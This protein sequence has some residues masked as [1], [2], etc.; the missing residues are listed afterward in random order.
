MDDLHLEE[1][2]RCLKPDDRTTMLV[3]V[4]AF[5]S[6]QHNHIMRSAIYG[7]IFALSGQLREDVSVY[8]IIGA[9]IVSTNPRRMEIDQHTAVCPRP[10]IKLTDIPKV[11]ELCAGIGC[12][13]VGLKH[14][15]MEIVLL[16]DISQ[17]IS[18]LSQQLHKCQTV[19]GDV[20]ND[21]T[22]AEVCKAV[23]YSCTVAGGVPC[24]PYSRLGDKRAKLDP[25]ARTLPSVLRASLLMRH[26]VVI[27]ECVDEAYKCDW[28]QTVLKTFQ[29]LTGYFLHQQIEQLSHVWPAKRNR[30]WCV[31]T[32]PMLGKIEWSNLPKVNPTPLVSHVID[33][34]MECT[35]EELK[36]LELDTYELRH[37]D[38]QGFH[39]NLVPLHGKMATSL[40]S[41]GN[42]F[43]AC[44]CKC[45]SHPFTSDRISTGL[46]SLLV[47]IKGEIKLAGESFPRH[48][49]IHPC[50]LALLNGMFPDMQW[51]D[52]VK[53]ALAG[54]GQLASPLQ[55]CWIGSHVCQHLMTKGLLNS[56]AS[57]PHEKLASL[58]QELLRSRDKC[59]GAPK[60]A[61]AKVFQAM[62]S[63]GKFEM[64]HWKTVLGPSSENHQKSAASG[65]TPPEAPQMQPICTHPQN[66][67]H[68]HKQEGISCKA[69]QSILTLSQGFGDGLTDSEFAE[70]LKVGPSTTCQQWMSNSGGVMGFAVKPP[71][72]QEKEE[73]PLASPPV[74]FDTT[75]PVGDVNTGIVNDV[76]VKE[77]S[78]EQ[79][80]TI[81]EDRQEEEPNKEKL[82][83]VL[84]LATDH[85]AFDVL[86]TPGSTAGQLTQAEVAMGNG[87]HPMF[88]CDWVGSAL[89][90][91]APLENEQVVVI[92]EA[93]TICDHGC[94]AK[95]PNVVA[96]LIS[97]PCDRMQ[98]LFQ[99]LGWVALDEMTFY[100]QHI[101]PADHRVVTPLCHA[102]GKPLQ[103]EHKEWISEMILN[104]HH[105]K[106]V[107]S[108]IL[109][110]QHWIPIITHTEDNEI[111]IGTTY[112][113]GIDQDLTD[114]IEGLTQSAQMFSSTIQVQR[115]SMTSLFQG[116]CGFQTVS[117]LKNKIHSKQ[118]VGMKPKEAERFRRLFAAQL[119]QDNN[120]TQIV[121]GLRMGGMIRD[122][123]AH[124]KLITLLIDHGVF[125]ERAKARAD[126]IQNK[127]SSNVLGGILQSPKPWHD[128]KAAA[129][130]LTP[131]LKLVMADE[132]EKQIAARS[133]D[134]TSIG[135]KKQRNMR[136]AK[137]KTQIQVHASALSVPAGVFKQEDGK[138]VS[139][140]RQDE[141]GPNAMG[142]VLLDDCEA[143][144]MLKL[145][146]P[147]S[148]HGLA[149]I[150]IPAPGQ[151]VDL[152]S[153]I[154]FPVMC[155]KTAEPMIIN[156]SI[157]QLGQQEIRRHEPSHKIAVDVKEASVI[158]CLTYKDQAGV[159]WNS[160]QQQPVKQ[161]FASTP[162]LTKQT[163]E[164]SVVMD[165][166]DRQW[167]TKR[168]ER[169]KY[170]QADIFAFSM[171]IAT[172]EVD[173]LLSQSGSKGIY[174]EPRST[175]G[176]MP[177]PE[178]HVTWLNQTNHSEAKIAQ[179]TS[180]Q[181]TT[182]V[183]HG[184]RYGLRSDSM[185]AQEIHAK[186]RPDTPMLLGNTK[187]LYVLGPLP[188][189]TT[190]EGVGKLLKAWQWDARALQ[191]R[192]RALDGTGINWSIQ[193]TEDP[194]HWIFTLQHGDV[195][196]TKA[197]AERTPV[198]PETCGIIASRKTIDQFKHTKVD[199]SW[200]K[201][202]PWGKYTPT[203]A[204]HVEAP[205]AQSSAGISNA[206][207]AAVEANVEKR[208]MA[209]LATRAEDVSM[210][211]NMHEVVQKVTQLEH[212][213]SQVVHHQQQVDSRLNG[214]Q[215]QMDQQASQFAT[216]VATQMTA[217]M[218]RIESLLAKRSRME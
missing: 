193:A 188:F 121:T 129:N 178:Y 152:Q 111:V 151:Q 60:E 124:A 7:Q 12:L 71:P 171:R 139:Q 134:P 6:E 30:W 27:L 131:V 98:A 18:E 146:R 198:P 13:G 73:V 118:D 26:A 175:C 42:Q 197:Q 39:N 2:I 107:V 83:I 93:N 15:G 203:T 19:V 104:T 120:A 162:E 218:E 117:W 9:K 101:C 47:K 53:L 128:L 50:E 179:Q 35:M 164:E 89:S 165:V 36:K 75:S 195:L 192:G 105:F 172:T 140:L 158:R 182:L 91:Y 90:L 109:Q 64:P 168:F 116:D 177:S 127:I 191:P 169:T 31:L 110:D 156:G 77:C 65:T 200:P 76:V 196:I 3:E 214:M 213:L 115:T 212:Q 201:G 52:N 149:I 11:I 22:M 87:D 32:H 92:H 159:L 99:Q 10:P 55:S 148:Q 33:H 88:P 216:A 153:S 180:P 69:G 40:H 155:I 173:G 183:R 25:R 123:D 81:E 70:A 136:A 189:S 17:P 106:Y 215:T 163:K 186:H 49:Y 80:A 167:F 141:V 37:F 176:R 29:T 205:R 41:I 21:L 211:A 170:D 67:H 154:R 137:E 160:L 202:D 94:P 51:G 184:D 4:L 133:K 23:P 63:Q 157:H 166:W 28:V 102:K 174:F 78:S 100:L 210:E 204:Q 66:T 181:A 147:V 43:T 82:Q 114:I 85:V 209:S 46:H 217:Q 138:L 59:F 1:D 143:E 142:V 126:V 24:Q 58:M 68:A 150:V 144:A 103:E 119:Y 84:Q 190:R 125:T 62:V 194:S 16:N 187:Q 145:T 113:L 74:P 72:N 208:V 5:D 206:Q 135:N 20:C 132:L 14:A 61:N 108:A 57:T 122:P 8:L 207:I 34:F 48:R 112:D 44:P 96:P 130:Q 161:I 86:V 56:H 199:D 54:L 185:N 97:F 79:P 95:K 38:Q 45:R